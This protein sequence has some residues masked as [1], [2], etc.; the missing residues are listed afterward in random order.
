METAPDSVGCRV[1]QPLWCAD[2]NQTTNLCSAI[3]LSSSESN[4]PSIVECLKSAFG[5]ALEQNGLE[6]LEQSLLPRA[7]TTYFNLTLQQCALSQREVE[8]LYVYTAS[9]SLL[10][11]ESR[12]SQDL[13]SGDKDKAKQWRFFL[14]YLFAALAKIPVW[15]NGQRSVFTLIRVTTKS[16]CPSPGSLQCQ[17]P[18]R[19]MPFCKNINVRGLQTH[20]SRLRGT[21]AAIFK[22]SRVCKQRKS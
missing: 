8:S 12:L 3:Q 2:T 9:Q 6:E 16:A 22:R 14:S 21:K 1:A 5:G 11:I 20:C 10:H 13:S 18:L 4:A 15:E 17:P 19:K 7:A